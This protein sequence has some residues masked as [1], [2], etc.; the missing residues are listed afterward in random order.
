[1]SV[2]CT[3]RVVKWLKTYRIEKIFRWVVRISGD[4]SK[5]TL[6]R[7]L[8]LRFR[9]TR[10]FWLCSLLP[11][12]HGLFYTEI[13]KYLRSR[14]ARGFFQNNTVRGVDSSSIGSGS[15]AFYQLHQGI[16]FVGVSINRYPRIAKQFLCQRTRK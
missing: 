11:F 13:G 5:E 3:N 1:M 7:A 9:E 8:Q 6:C 15:L 16:T 14:R 2:L 4:T 10:T 12:R